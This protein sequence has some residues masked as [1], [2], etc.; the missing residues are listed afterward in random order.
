[1]KL[2]WRLVVLSISYTAQGEG[3]PR[4]NE[5]RNGLGAALASLTDG[6]RTPLAR[7]FSLRY[8]FPNE[9]HGLL[10]RPRETISQSV[11]F[12]LTR[13]RFPI[14][15]Q[16]DDIS[17][18]SVDLYPVVSGTITTLP[19]LSFGRAGGTQSDI[20]LAQT[21]GVLTGHVSELMGD[22]ESGRWAWNFLMKVY[23]AMCLGISS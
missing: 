18:A 22:R 20:P 7:G 8:E 1:M 4:K 16:R 12:P 5:V 9:W 3:E 15:A 10:T 2:T 19:T 21:G 14:L 6:S 17:I 13:E 11:T 23:H